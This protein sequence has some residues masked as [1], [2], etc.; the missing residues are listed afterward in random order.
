MTT[1]FEFMD[2]SYK[3]QAKK[4]NKLRETFVLDDMT[5]EATVLAPY[6]AALLELLIRLTAACR[7]YRM[8]LKK[9]GHY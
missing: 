6:A 9:H 5:A 7:T 3:R 2:D 1:V 8:E 4:M